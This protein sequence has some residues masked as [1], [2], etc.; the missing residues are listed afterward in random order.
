MIIMNAIKILL[1][2]ASIDKKYVTIN[3]LT[4]YE[5][6]KATHIN[7][8]IYSITMHYFIAVVDIDLNVVTQG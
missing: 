2:G 1:H 3:K 8:L 6:L 7:N 4:D 5:G